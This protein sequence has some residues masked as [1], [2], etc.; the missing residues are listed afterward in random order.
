MNQFKLFLHS[1]IV[2][3]ILVVQ[4]LV[5]LFELS[6]IYR[7][8]QTG[9]EIWPFFFM[10]IMD[11]PIS[12]LAFQIAGLLGSWAGGVFGAIFLFILMVVL[13]T[14]WWAF[15]IFMLRWFFRKIR[16]WLKV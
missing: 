9:S 10:F 11:L 1:G 2:R 7:S 3:V 16:Q 12:M 5:G 13:G 4:C 8:A 6:Q 14:L 15:L